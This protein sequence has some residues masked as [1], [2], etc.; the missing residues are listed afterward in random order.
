VI[1]Y[2]PTSGLEI[3]GAASL[4]KIYN[5]GNNG[6]G[7]REEMQLDERMGLATEGVIIASVE[8]PILTIL[9][10]LSILTILTILSILT[11]LTILSIPSTTRRCSWT[12]AWASPPRASSSPPSRYQY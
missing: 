10:I 9:S 11:I 2:D 7:N 3:L 12:S 8:V 4:M 5:D 1:E 6:T